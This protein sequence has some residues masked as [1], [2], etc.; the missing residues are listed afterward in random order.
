MAF[1]YPAGSPKRALPGQILLVVHDF[2]ARSPDELSLAKGDR[3]ELIERDDDFGDGWYLGKHMHNGNTG[4]FP[5]VYT[6][7]APRGVASLAT[8]TRPFPH[9]TDGMNNDG[10]SEKGVQNGTDDRPVSPAPPRTETPQPSGHSNATEYFDPDAAT[11]PPLNTPSQHF[12]TGTTVTPNGN[13]S[14]AANSSSGPRSISMA[15]RNENNHGQDSP[16]MNET[17]SVIDEHITDMSTPRHSVATGERRGGTNDSG[18]E[19]SSHIDHRLSYITGHETD[20][21]EQDTPSQAEILNWTPAQVAR[22]LRECGVEARHCEV[23]E[24]QEISGEVLLGLDQASLF[25]K[26]FDLGPVGRRLRTWHKIK[27]LQQEVKGFGRT[28][29][30]QSAD[31]Y[32]ESH[33]SSEDVSKLRGNGNATVLPRIP[34][35]MEKPNMARNGNRRSNQQSSR[36]PNPKPDPDTPPTTYTFFSGQESPRRPSAASIRE[37]NQSR[38]HSSIDFSAQMDGPADAGLITLQST[39]PAHKKQASFDNTWTLGVPVS[40]ASTRPA[41]SAGAGGHSHSKSSDRMSFNAVG[42]TSVSTTTPGDL[43]R[44]YFSGGEVDSRKGRNVL[45]KKDNISHSRNSSYNDDHKRRS[46]AG[47]RR[48]SRFGSADSARDMVSSVTSPA[49]KNYYGTSYKDRFRAASAGEAGVPVSSKDHLAPT[50]TKLDYDHKSGPGS[51]S[52]S[53][54]I[55]SDISSSGPGSPVPPL[56]TSKM[57]FRSR[58]L[59]IRAISDAVTR[60][61]RGPFTS[62]ESNRSPIKGS[63]IQSPTRTGSSTPSAASKSLDLDADASKV[64]NGQITPSSSTKRRKSKK[65]TSAYVRGLEKKTPQEQMIDCDYCGWMKKKSSNL[66]TTWKPRLFILRGR[67]LS[68]YYSED[69]EQEKGLIDISFH[70]VLPADSDR[71]TGLHATLTGATASSVS[72]QNSLTPTL[73]S[74]EAALEPESL[75]AVKSGSGDAMFIF[76]LVPPRPGLSRA[77]TFTKPTVHYFAVDNVKQGRLWM[78]ALMKA[79]IERDESKQ[80]ITSYQQKTISLA[81]AK[82]MREQQPE[83]LGLNGKTVASTTRD[84][85]KA[86]GGGRGGGVDVGLRIEGVDLT[87]QDDGDGNVT[88]P[89]AR[90]ASFEASLESGGGD[91]LSLAPPA[92]ILS[93]ITG[94][95]SHA[96]TTPV[97]SPTNSADTKEEKAS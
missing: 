56:P 12:Q 65:E 82:A 8:I 41:S 9:P 86:N 81:R 17:L 43:D 71:I 77:V 51:V 19:Y 73:A 62:S 60:I 15:L 76:K 49:S 84:V 95:S 46:N 85:E 7:P 1:R 26:E 32:G 25:I 37:L 54:N 78:A 63:P 23:F 52:P 38:R 24:E 79:T 4:L 21:E 53:V 3:I 91:V 22:Y 14:S 69:D 67:R 16:V 57:K 40:P 5:E 36:Q 61:E 58:G 35:L 55:G 47:L 31:E 83:L 44:G 90:A 70:R 39:P 64:A 42:Y 80:V 30:H 59:G 6:T 94:S 18:S 2:V 29:S 87:G 93:P 88:T 97:V 45:R 10:A 27:G 74:T 96:I 33:R 20:E 11:P 50:V 28:R 34:S 68:Y 66:M 48:H 89:T 75:N 72:P 13:T 92:P